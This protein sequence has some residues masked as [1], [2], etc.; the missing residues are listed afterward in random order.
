MIKHRVDTNVEG[1]MLVENLTRCAKCNKT[2][3]P[4]EQL[5]MC[6]D[7]RSVWYCTV[8]CQ[9]A[10][11]PL[12]KKYC[13]QAKMLIKTFK[14]VNSINADN[15]DGDD[16]LFD[17]KLLTMDDCPIC[18][19]PLPITKSEV[20]YK[21]CCGQVMCASC[22]CEADRTLSETNNKRT[23]ADQP[24]LYS[25]CAYCGQIDP[26]S[27]EEE[28]KYLKKRLEQ[29]DAEAFLY[30]SRAHMLGQ[31]GL[32]KNPQK[33]F[34]LCQKAIEIEPCNTDA[35]SLIARYYEDGLSV[36]KSITKARHHDVLGAKA[37]D[38]HSRYN[39][40]CFEYGRGNRSLAIK[41]WLIAATIGQTQALR[42]IACEYKIGGVSKNKYKNAI[43]N[44]RKIYKA[45]WSEQRE[46][47]KMEHARLILSNDE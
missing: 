20:M 44:Y 35:H 19:I 7:C 43:L 6:T 32:P 12:H 4:F 33:G 9:K 29:N 13:K 38:Y 46:R 30:A 25:H 18:L 23:R 17:F 45:C 47:F 15:D 10:H 27:D 2:S 1:K 5:K 42:Y 41:H 22:Q 34:E 14:D 28:L 26:R 37:G 21:V 24:Q 36:Q 3:E 16:N 40:G 31:C 39:L 11:R 8:D